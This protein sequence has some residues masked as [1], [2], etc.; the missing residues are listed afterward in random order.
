MA[1]S[2]WKWWISKPLVFLAC[3]A[4]LAYLLYRASTAQLSANPIDDITDITGRWTLRFIMIAL[5]VTPVRRITG[6]NF[7]TRFRRMIGLFAFFYGI[8]HF[9]TY[10]WLDQGLAWE[11][12]LVDL[13]KRP[14]ITAGF[15]ALVL[16]LPLAL[17]STKRWIIRLGGRRWQWLH[18]LI[19]VSAIAAVA[20][21]IW[22]VKLDRTYPY[23]YGMLLAVLLGIR[24]WF[25]L[26]PRLAARRL[27][28]PVQSHFR[29]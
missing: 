4:P 14:F 22:L 7:V 12:V 24:V 15:T 19:Y 29:P 9:T 20:H 5:A 17:T 26:K 25:A 8:L 1:S 16:M 6:W 27:E 2:R 18:R 13:P 28:T 10:I 23:R 3:L 21:Y 11:G